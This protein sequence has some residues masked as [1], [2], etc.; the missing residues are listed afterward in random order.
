MK[1]HGDGKF[2]FSDFSLLGCDVVFERDVLIFH[3]N[4]IEIGNNVYIGHQTILK[5]YYKN[6]MVIGNNTWIGQQCFFHSAGGLFIGNNVGI[7]PAVRIITSAHAADDIKKPI[8]KTSLIF[9]KVVIE[10]NCDIGTGTII[11]PGVTIGESTILGAGSI[12]TKNIPPNSVA[13]GNP[14]KVIKNRQ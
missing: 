8:I 5:G 3:P 10:N 4:N 11:L 2:R 7:G 1:S 6:K 9:K 12:V 13:V 14:A